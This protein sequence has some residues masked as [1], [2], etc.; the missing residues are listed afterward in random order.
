M[1]WMNDSHVH[2]SLNK[3]TSSASLDILSIPRIISFD[4]KCIM[5]NQGVRLACEY[6]LTFLFSYADAWAGVV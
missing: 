1:S 6:C 5:G 2:V 4:Y 3:E